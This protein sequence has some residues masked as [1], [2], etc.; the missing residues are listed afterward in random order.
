MRVAPIA[1]GH[2][3]VALLFMPRRTAGVA[4]AMCAIVVGQTSPAR[5]S[6]DDW[7]GLYDLFNSL[8]VVLLLA[9]A[10]AWQ[11]VPAW[12]ISWAA[13]AVSTGVAMY[14]VG[15]VA[16]FLGPRGSVALLWGFV[17]LLPWAVGR[18][19]RWLQSAASLLL[20][21]GMLS[22]PLGRLVGQKLSPF[23][24]RGTQASVAALLLVA[25][26]RALSWA[27]GPE[28][29]DADVVTDGLGYS[30]ALLTGIYV[31]SAL[32]Y[33]RPAQWLLSQLYMWALLAVALRLGDVRGAATSMRS[34]V[35]AAAVG[36]SV[37]KL[38]DAFC[39]AGIGAVGAA[40][41]F[42]VLWLCVQRS[43][44]LDRNMEQEA[45]K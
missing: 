45:Q 44:K 18:R 20:F 31:S 36:Y 24:D 26:H 33:E 43:R 42:A 3:L 22:T 14:D 1:M 16:A 6:E 17:A 2:L 37:V 35:A 5:R 8:V 13:R 40:V 15:T 41:W 10:V 25:V 27:A 39:F 12:C 4:L 23:P 28:G 11:Y 19:S 34:R 29:I 7:M 9:A 38:C 21:A 32:L 30:G